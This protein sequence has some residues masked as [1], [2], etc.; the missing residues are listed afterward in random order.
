MPPAGS[1]GVPPA[2]HWQRFTHLLDRAR[3]AAAPRFCFGRAHA[4]PA[5]RVTGLPHHGKTERP[6]NAENAGET[7]A[8]PEKLLPSLLL[9]EGARGGLLGR[10][11]CRCGRA[12]SASWPFVVLRVS[13]WKTLFSVA[14]TP[15]RDCPPAGSAGVPPAQ[16]WQRF[17][18]LLDRARP[19]T[20]PRFRFG[21]AHAV[22]AGRVTGL[23]HHGETKR[24]PNA[25]NAGETPA[26]PERAPLPSL[27]LLQ[28]GRLSLHSCFSSGQTAACWAAGRADAVQASRF[29]ALRRPSCVFVENSFFRSCD[30]VTGGCPPAGSA[31]VSPAQHWQRLTHLLDRAR[32]ATAAGFRFGRAQAVA[33][34]SVTGCRCHGETERPPNAENAGETPALP[35]KLL[36]SLLP[37]Q[38]PPCHFRCPKPCNFQC[39]LT[40]APPPGS[41]GVSP[42]QHWQRFTHLLDRAR[43]ATA[44][45]FRLGRA[46]AVAAGSVTGCRCHGETKRPPNAENAGETPA[47]GARASRPHSRRSFSHPSCSSQGA[48]LPSLLLLQ[49]ARGG[50]LGR[51]PCR[52]GAAVPLRGPSSTFVCLR[53]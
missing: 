21:R 50:L 46:Q 34:G 30:A 42:A 53:G 45:G 3:P 11:P 9:L 33:A 4:V 22:P 6:P 14:A 39:P 27:L 20:A 52:C 51:R 23:P 41:A 43:P 8:L 12:R 25:E 19:A 48:P 5:G 28:G 29:V 44:P 49:G 40:D 13:S 17:T 1:A 35:E 24:P 32:P 31:G 36:P 2:Q 38:G 15:S 18:H 47:P 16:H 37:L 26:L 10:R 7:P